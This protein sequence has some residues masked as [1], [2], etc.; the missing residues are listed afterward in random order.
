MNNQNNT[1]G[2]LNERT[3]HR[4]LKEFYSRENGKTEVNIMGF[5]ADVFDGQTIT[6]IQS[7]QFRNLKKKLCMFSDKYNVRIVYP[8]ARTK[9]LSWLD[10]DTGE[11]ISRRKSPKKG[12]SYDILP[13]IYELSEFIGH[14][15][16]SFEA[17]L[18][19]VEEYRVK[20]GFGKNKKRRPTHLDKIPQ[21]EYERV[22][23]KTDAD[24][25]N[26]VSPFLPKN[27]TADIFAKSLNRNIRFAYRALKV[28][29][30]TN[31]VRRK[32]KDGRKILYELC[33]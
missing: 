3:L 20:D 29:C 23:F 5:T 27:F 1:I 10:K 16:I 31:A 22:Q 28:L 21:R 7:A 30:I 8:I 12:F 19:D 2:T 11:I 24:Y 17:V 32:G 25:L 14:K 6:E 13:Q 4:E 15:N 9:Y 33:E 18:T 26:C